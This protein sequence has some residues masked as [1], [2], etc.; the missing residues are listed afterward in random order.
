MDTITVLPESSS[1]FNLQKLVL[2]DQL[3]DS[4]VNGQIAYICTPEVN[5]LCQIFL[6]KIL[7]PSFCY[8]DCSVA[9][10]GAYKK[11]NNTYP[12][13][14][15]LKSLTLSNITNILPMVD[16]IKSVSV[17]LVFDTPLSASKWKSN[18]NYFRDIVKHLLQLFVLMNG[19]IISLEAVKTLFDV[20]IEH[21]YIE[22]M[23]VNIGHVVSATKVKIEKM[24]SRLTYEQI[25]MNV[26]LPLIGGLEVPLQKLRSIIEKLKMSEEGLKYSQYKQVCINIE[27]IFLV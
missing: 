5:C 18:L 11:P 23:D 6:S 19:A 21:I 3:Y 27:V 4:S 9:N 10:P 14:I 2:S 17:H 12:S 25:F 22:A 13:R 1:M 8:I 15:K 16:N 24:L 7:H 20:N 26:N